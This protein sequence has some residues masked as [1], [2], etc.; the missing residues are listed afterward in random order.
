MSSLLY[1]L[2]NIDFKNYQVLK[3]IPKGYQEILFKR[4]IPKF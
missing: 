4:I 1:R 3:W 2:S